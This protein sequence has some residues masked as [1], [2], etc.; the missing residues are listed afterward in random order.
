[1]PS[2][3]ACRLRTPSGPLHRTSLA[4]CFLWLSQKG[5]NL[6]SVSRVWG[7]TV[8]IHSSNW[9]WV[10]LST[11]WYILLKMQ[12]NHLKV[13][14]L[15][16]T[17]ELQK[18]NHYHQINDLVFSNSEENFKFWLVN[19]MTGYATYRRGNELPLWEPSGALSFHNAWCPL[20]PT[21]Q[22]DWASGSQQCQPHVA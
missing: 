16:H 21:P 13:R 6:I 12:K 17:G 19:K 18:E 11:V 14:N 2:C 15:L 9:L 20:N 1:M 5:T 10:K 7:A 3:L 4:Q 22:R 8:K